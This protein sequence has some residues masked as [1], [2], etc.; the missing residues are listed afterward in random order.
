ML[1]VANSSGPSEMQ[2]VGVPDGRADAHLIC[3][4][5]NSGG[6]TRGGLRG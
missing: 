2:V 4:G 3:E 1:L 5:L 6:C